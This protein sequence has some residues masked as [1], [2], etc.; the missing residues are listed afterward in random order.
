ML[1]HHIY[2]EDHTFYPMV[3]KELSQDE[4]LGF[5][6]LFDQEQERSEGK[7]IAESRKLLHE[8]ASM[9]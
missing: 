7:G 2:K 8:M 9:L 3:E 1:R 5:N 6:K 4:L